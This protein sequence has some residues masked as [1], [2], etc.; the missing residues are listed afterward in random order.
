MSEYKTIRYEFKASYI[1]QEF[2][3]LALH[4]Y[5]NHFQEITNI[6][7]YRSGNMMIYGAQSYSV[8]DQNFLFLASDLDVILTINGTISLNL[9]EFVLLQK[10]QKFSFEIKAFNAHTS[11][12]NAN[13]HFLH[14]KV[15]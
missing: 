7:D 1:D 5:I 9:S 10:S 12:C 15:L 3:P 2:I 13:I 6:V 8:I 14:G 11:P 4:N